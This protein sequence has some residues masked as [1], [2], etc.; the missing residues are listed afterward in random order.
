M[1]C[2]WPM[3][4]LHREGANLCA[5]ESQ[6]ITQ[7]HTEL[8]LE[9]HVTLPQGTVSCCASPGSPAQPG[10][11]AWEVAQLET[12]SRL[13]DTWPALNCCLCG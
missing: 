6:V 2:C 10:P 9:Q 8:L 5:S 7:H 4:R 13:R 3:A 1:L 11:G 12:F